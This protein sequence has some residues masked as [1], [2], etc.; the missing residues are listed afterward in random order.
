MG[1]HP[2]VAKHMTKTRDNL[3]ESGIAEP[4]RFDARVSRVFADMIKRSVPGYGLFLETLA[5][6]ARQFL[7]EGGHVYDL[8]CSLGA[9]S[10]AIQQAVPDRA[11]RLTAVDNS[12]AM[13]EHARAALMDGGNAA[14]VQLL[15]ADILEIEFDAPSLV[16]LGFT[17]QFLPFAARNQLLTRIAESMP[18]DG[19]VVLAEKVHF[20]DPGTQ[21]LQTGLHLEFK[22]TQAYSELEISGK[23][24]ALENVLITDTVAEH[25]TRLERAGFECV[26]PVLQAFN[27]VT[28]L[29]QRR[30]RDA[31]E[32]VT[33][34]H[35]D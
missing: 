19:V 17:L 32:Y 18:D 2:R 28:L 8:G 33:D 22:R 9:C 27:F 7:R 6:V 1:P 29:A 12:P 14:S 26:T 10:L 30:M 4:F 20:D 24:Q 23:R 3:F 13:I 11:F 5:V 31:H 15:E 21:A 35:H 34:P 16:V 25:V